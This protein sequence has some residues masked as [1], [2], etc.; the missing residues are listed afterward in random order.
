MKLMIS[1][2]YLAI[3]CLGGPTALNAK[4]HRWTHFGLRPLAM[5]NAYVAVADDFNASFYNPAG[6]ARLKDW[7]GE[8]LNPSFETAQ[9][10][11]DFISETIEL[12]QG[13]TSGFNEILDLFNK[14]SGNIHHMAFHDTPHFVTPN[15]GIALGTELSLGLIAHRNIEIEIDAGP[16]IIAPISYARNFLDD[17]LSLGASIKFLLRSGLSHNFNVQ[18]ISAFSSTDEND[19]GGQT[20]E[21]SDLFEGGIGA[22][23]DLGL[24]FTP[25]KKMTPTLGVSIT[26]FMGSIYQKTDLGSV[27]TKAPNN[28]LPSVNTG[29]SFKPI[30]NKR[31]Y[32]LVAVDAHSINQPIHYSQK[33]NLGVEWSYGSILKLQTGLKAGYLTAGVQLDVGLLNIRFA[34]YAVDHGPVVGIH[35]SLV[36]RRYALQMKLFI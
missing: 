28:R 36:E 35:P 13:D 4:E 3:F 18:T 1:L 24:L 20:T 32:L 19:Q 17:R 31:S 34:T 12:A 9:E 11:I 14:Q 29:I 16:R 6:L 8:F 30:S 10:T 5:G 23:M 33:F 27:A 22:G 25:T 7:D 15:F 2:M 26:D 21:L